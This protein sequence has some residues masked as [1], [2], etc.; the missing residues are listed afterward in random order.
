MLAG[1]LDGSMRER[2]I[3]LAGDH[4]RN[5]LCSSSTQKLAQILSLRSKWTCFYFLTAITRLKTVYT[6][7]A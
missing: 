6:G 3:G 7:L 4:D 5:V 2:T 1:W